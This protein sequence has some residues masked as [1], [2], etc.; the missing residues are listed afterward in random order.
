MGFNQPQ[1]IVFIESVN[2]L[3]GF[4]KNR[5][6]QKIKVPEKHFSTQLSTALRLKEKSFDGFG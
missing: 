1:T 5:P 4:A 2:A 6:F 3:C